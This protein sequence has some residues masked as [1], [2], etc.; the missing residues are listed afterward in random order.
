MNHQPPAPTAVTR[1][2]LA[3]ALAVCGALLLRGC[4]DAPRAPLAVGMG[5]WVGYDPMVLAR[6]RDLIDA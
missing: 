3:C 6:D 5:A 4:G 1:R 2:R